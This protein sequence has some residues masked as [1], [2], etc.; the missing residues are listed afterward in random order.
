MNCSEITLLKRL[1]GQMGLFLHFYTFLKP[2]AEVIRTFPQ[3]PGLVLFGLTMVWA[4]RGC[5]QRLGICIGLHAGLVWGYYILNVGE[6]IE[7]PQK[8]SPWITGV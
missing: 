7:Y 6:L 4:K 3:F 8:V 1:C 5:R 2:I